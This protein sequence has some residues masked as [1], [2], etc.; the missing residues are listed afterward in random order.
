M[1]VD[2]THIWECE[3]VNDDNKFYFYTWFALYGLLVFVFGTCVTYALVL[4]F[5]R[6]R[7]NIMETPISKGSGVV[8]AGGLLSLLIYSILM[9]LRIQKCKKKPWYKI[10]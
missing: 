7:W 5:T 10:F 3:N 4:V 6:A 2:S 9:R 1:T 8:V